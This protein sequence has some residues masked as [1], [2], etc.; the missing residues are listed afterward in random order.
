[1]NHTQQIANFLDR[2]A[3]ALQWTSLP[4]GYSYDP[5]YAYGGLYY[6]GGMWP[7]RRPTVKQLAA[8][9]ADDAEFDA[10]RLGDWTRTPTGELV[11]RLSGYLV[12]PTEH[13]DLELLVSALQHAADAKRADQKQAENAWLLVA[14]VTAAVFVG[15]LSLASR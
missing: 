8:Q 3:A 1:M 10:L 15:L 5:D 11:V 6:D 9:M 12:T 2:Y 4:Y 13:T 7:V 14:G